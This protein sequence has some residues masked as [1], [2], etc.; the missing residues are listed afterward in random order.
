MQAKRPALKI[1]LWLLAA[2]LLGGA[3]VLRLRTHAAAPPESAQAGPQARVIPVITTTV[4]QTDLPIEL[5]G[6]GTVAPIQTVTIRSQVDGRLEKLFFKEGQAVKRGDLLAQID[7]RPFQIQLKQAEG[8]LARDQATLDSGGQNLERLAKLS[9]QKFVSAQDLQNQQALVGGLAGTVRVDE[10]QVESARLSLAYAR[11]T[12]P[13]DGVTGIRQVDPGNLVRA[14]DATGI[15][16]ITQLDPIAVVFTLPQDDLPRVAEQLARGATLEVDAYDRSG[17]LKLATG[18]LELIDNQVA[19]AT[20]SIRLKAFFPNGEHRLWPNLFVKARLHL[21]TRKGVLAVPSIAVQR[22][23]KGVLVYVVE[24][25]QT[26]AIRPIEIEQT[27]GELTVIKRGLKAGEQVVVE[28]Q[29]QLRP[30]ARVSVRKQS[31]SLPS[32][33]QAGALR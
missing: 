9:G 11:I 3:L 2:L 19:T 22:G 15:V 28:G 5:E 16:L 12:S 17:L 18:K 26:A 7:P 31:G 6:L 29:N 13:L 10:A 4:E 33:R 8:S 20:A 30:G 23:P 32:E 21:E 27:V 25:D 24:G 1:T 14:S